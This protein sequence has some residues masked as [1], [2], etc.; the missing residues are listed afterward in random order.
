[1]KK[2]AVLLIAFCVVACSQE[3]SQQERWVKIYEG[4][5]GRIYYGDLESLDRKTNQGWVRI[6]AEKAP[7]ER[8]GNKKA[9]SVMNLIKA[10]C[11]EKHIKI[12]YLIDKYQDGT[13]EKFENK[14][15]LKIYAEPETSVEATLDWLCGR[16][17]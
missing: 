13:K 15:N 4:K 16:K 10:D 14:E 12:V 6:D 2:I 11:K 1:M 3:K 9:T 8:G 17:M 7:L 5:T